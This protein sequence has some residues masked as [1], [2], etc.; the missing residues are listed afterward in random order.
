MRKLRP[1]QTDSTLLFAAARYDHIDVE[2]DLHMH[3]ELQ[4]ILVTEGVLNMLINGKE[5]EIP[6]DFGVFVPSY[7]PH[8]FYRRQ[9]NLNL[10]ILFSEELVPA[11]SAYLQ[12]H[13]PSRHIFAVSSVSVA[14][15]EQIL[16]HEENTVDAISAQAVLASLCRDA[17]RTA[18]FEERKP[19][20]DYILQILEYVNSHFREE[21]SLETVARAVG[22]HPVTVSKLLS[23][24]TGI[25]FAAHLQYQRCSYGAKL[26]LASNLRVSEIALEAGFGSTRSFHR[27]FRAIYGRTPTQYRQEPHW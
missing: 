5:Y 14:L 7:S 6:K 4:F 17:Y 3:P 22:V 19:A 15:T 23:K 8:K 25:S 24:Q 10:V 13:A 21:I 16:P 12:T 11:F 20:D 9:P 27:A 1:T 2:S 18:V 26:L